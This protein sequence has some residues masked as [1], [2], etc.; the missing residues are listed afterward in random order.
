MRQQRN[1]LTE[2]LTLE[3]KLHKEQGC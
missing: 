2:I 3:D 1:K